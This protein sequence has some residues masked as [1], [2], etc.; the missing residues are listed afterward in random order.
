MK[1]EVFN[2]LYSNVSKICLSVIPE[3]HQE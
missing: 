1:T 2:V 3:V